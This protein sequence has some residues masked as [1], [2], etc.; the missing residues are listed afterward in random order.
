MK[1]LNL[2]ADALWKQRFKLPT[3]GLGAAAKQRPNRVLVTT[4]QTDT[5]QLYALDAA[6]GQA[7]QV[8]DKPAGKRFGAISA[9]G[10]F[11][12]YLDDAQGDERGHWVRVPFTG[13]AAQ[14]LTPDL[15]VYSSFSLTENHTDSLIALVAATADGFKT[16]LM[17][18]DAERHVGSP[19]LL[20]TSP[21]LTPNPALSYDGRLLVIGS[22]HRTGKNA[23]SLLAFD[24]ESG[25]QI[26][27]LWLAGDASLT[28]TCFSPIDGDTRLLAN[29]DE[30][31]FAR[32]LLWNPLTGERT[33]LPVPG[34]EGDIIPTDWSPSGAQILLLQIHQAQTQWYTYDLTDGTLTRVAHPG[35]TYSGGVYADE[36]TFYTLW[37]DALHPSRLVA[38]DTR[39]G[40][41][42]TVLAGG[43]EAPGRPWRSVTFPS[44]DGTP[45]QAWVATPEGDGPFPTILHT[46]GGPT[47]VETEVFD[48]AAQAWLDHGFAFISVNYRG[49]VTFGK[50]FEHAI[51]GRL[52]H[53]EVEDMAAARDWLVDHGIAEADS[54]LVTGGSYG[55][56][57]TLQALGKR[58]DLWAGGM[59]QV[60][61]ADWSIMYEDEADTLRGYQ[62]AL[63]GGSPQETPDAHRAS[64]PLTYAEAVR[65]PVLV[66]QGANDTRCPAR[67]M[68]VYE[69]TLREQG[70]DIQ[71]EWF[72]AGHGS[73][74]VDERIHH[75]ETMLRFAYRVL[76]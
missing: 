9:D 13:G 33:D 45:I 25:E 59:A 4:N 31:G 17:S 53:L 7:Q 49:S 34:L 1:P 61:I 64:S 72:D 2:N 68:R 12:Y 29:A 38:V 47:A 43:D 71:V 40:A 5:Y 52:G 37:T 10:A 20:H 32:P 14:D 57:L 26:A 69:A 60:A 58:P 30:S 22:N 35:G 44:A 28:A 51:W 46:H 70:K 16:Y 24:T 67:Q 65:A 39:T 27:E 41:L 75:M 56:Y 21:G 36:T 3:V 11:I 50:A 6:S 15:P 55:G 42:R 66:I 23:F 54:I 76:G 62:R 73:L 63:F 8:T 74:S 48:A 18:Q 19:R